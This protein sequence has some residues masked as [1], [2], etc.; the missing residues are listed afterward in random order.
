METCIVKIPLLPN[1]ALFVI[2]VYYPSGN[3]NSHFKND[4]N[5]LFQHLNLE[6]PNNLYILCGDLNSKHSDWGNNPN[7]AK[8]NILKEW[9][10]SNEIRFRC[11]LYASTTPSYPRCGSFLDVCIADVRLDIHRENNTLNCLRTLDY[12]SDHN[13]LQILLMNNENDH[14]LIFFKKSPDSKLNYKKANWKKFKNNISNV[15]RNVDQVPNDRNL[16][17]SEIDFYL[18]KL[19][20][21][22]LEAAE[23]S[24]P[25]FK[26][27][28]T[29]ERFITPVIKKLEAE[30]SRIL[31]IIKKHN[32][33]EIIRTPLQI[34]LLKANLKLIRKLIRDN[35]IIATNKH[36]QDRLKCIDHRNS[37]HMF[38]EV[39]KQFRTTQS[40]DI[41]ML[42]IAQE[43]EMLLRNAGINSREIER[44]DNSFVVRDHEQI[45]NLIGAS[46]ESVHAY[47]ELD[48]GNML[49]VKVDNCFSRFLN[50]K[51]EY[52]CNQSTITTFSENNKADEINESLAQDI[53]IDKNTLIYIFSK[54]RKKLSSGT[55]NI[56]NILLRNIPEETILEYCKLFNNMLNN[57]YFP[58]AWKM[59]KVV[60][61]PKKGKD[62]SNPKNL[63]AISLLPNISKVFE[64]CINN[65]LIKH[66]KRRKLINDK[67][68]GFKFKHSTINAIHL[69]VSNVQW[70]LKKSFCTA[71]CLIDFEKAFDSIWIPGLIYKLFEYKFPLYLIILL[72]NMLNNKSFLVSN[73]NKISSK[74]FVIVNGL[75][76]GTVN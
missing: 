55:D 39:K 61:L 5:Q 8:G 33:L 73:Q 21:I 47:K 20:E 57:S 70:S 7:N 30:K 71:A 26:N 31:T 74:S 3:N 15:F 45:L 22:I 25:K 63:R 6:D 62:I 37:S 68:F 66:C 75:Q 19:N 48:Y 17:N 69:F 14:P 12:D 59:A 10:A 29:T 54:L 28:D 43:D 65:N 27:F 35:F 52:E 1:K 64:I 72:H 9:L 16:T 42:K 38:S 36:F 50:E 51:I 2:S 24:V 46:I 32:R 4:F 40:L 18:L 49:H 23:K 44:E 11:S 13:A 60:V 58:R 76:Q 67:Q 53:F 34:N 56:P 41:N